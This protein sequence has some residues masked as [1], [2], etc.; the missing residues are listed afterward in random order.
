MQRPEDS[1]EA[2]AGDLRFDV[3]PNG[4]FIDEDV[5]I[6]LS[7][8]AP[9]QSVRIHATTEDDENRRWMSDATFRAD[10]R[11]Q[12]DLATQE[13]TAGT[14]RG[15]APMGLFWSMRLA[16]G[17]ENDGAG[18][19]FTKKDSLPH[20]VMLEVELDR[21]VMIVSG[22]IERSFHARGTVIRDLMVTG[23]NKFETAKTSGP[24]LPT[25]R[26]GRLF[27]PPATGG[28][29]A[30]PAVIVLSGSG[31]GFDLDKAAVLSRHGFATLALAYFGTRPLAQ[32]L[33]RV[34]LEYIEA[35]LAWL[36]EQP[37]IDSRRMGVLGVSRGAELAMLSASRFSNIR[38][39]V[40]YAPSSVAWDSGGHDKSTGENIPAWLW[41]GEPVASVPLPLRSFMWRSAIPVVAMR[42]PVMFR[43]LFRA[44]LRN[45]DAVMR[46]GIPAEQ[47]NGPL[48]L[49]S[50]GDDHVWPAQEMAEAIVARLKE[51]GF[52]HDVE[53][54]HYPAAGHLL[55][56][57]HLP[58]TAR[59]SRHEYLR[60]AR[61]SFGG[62]PRAD[63]EAQ[64]DS[65]HR[66]IAFLNKHL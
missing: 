18:A 38:A 57:P 30:R 54:L 53:H 3:P 45:Q 6:R 61:F 25:G 58:T 1:I 26:V 50:G 12:V 39:V 43:N 63:A 10:S 24:G 40:A 36:A 56:Y 42:R 31:G 7:G 19:T 29:G 13:P 15:V 8:L 51:R 46:A 62:S 20:A 60:G 34:P 5:E 11:G 47:I 22:R 28:K 2:H 48:L 41:R 59:D 66:A 52:Q 27:L 37:E 4:A 23:G 65:W 49:I 14:Y 55:R 32:W 35:A 9:H 17:S 21:S 44:G 33:H 16:N 64:A